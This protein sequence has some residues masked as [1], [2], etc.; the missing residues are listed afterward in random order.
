MLCVNNSHIRI[1][2]IFNSRFHQIDQKPALLE[3]RGKY[4][5]K[6]SDNFISLLELEPVASER[7]KETRKINHF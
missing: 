4:I 7:L 6:L 3:I 1:Q 5:G 2:K